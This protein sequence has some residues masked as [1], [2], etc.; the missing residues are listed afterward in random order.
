[1]GGRK[2]LSPKNRA[3]VRI[4]KTKAKLPYVTYISVKEYPSIQRTKEIRWL[5]TFKFGTTMLPAPILYNSL[6]PKFCDFKGIS[7]KTFKALAAMV[8]CELMDGRKYHTKGSIIPYMNCNVSKKEWE[9]ITSYLVLW[10]L[11]IKMPNQKGINVSR[12]FMTAL[13]QGLL[14]EFYGYCAQAEQELRDRIAKRE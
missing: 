12:Y 2:Y 1:M 7:P 14:N 9:T 10:S 5:D 3:G 6:V 4:L 8:M 13:G 11:V